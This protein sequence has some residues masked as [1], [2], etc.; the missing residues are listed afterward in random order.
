MSGQ[1]SYPHPVLGVGDDVAGTFE[2]AD[3]AAPID[4]EHDTLS[5]TG[6]FDLEHDSIRK[7]VEAGD[8]RISV[9][10][11]CLVTQYR[12]S[13]ALKDCSSFDLPMP[14]PALSGAVDVTPMVVSSVSMSDYQPQGMHAD[15]GKATFA[16]EPGSVIAVGSSFQFS[17]DP[18]FNGLKDRAESLIVFRPDERLTAQTPFEVDP[19]LP[20]RLVIKVSTEDLAMLRAIGPRVPRTIMSGLVVAAIA[21]AIS[22]VKHP[23]S[24]DESEFESLPWFQRMNELHLR[25]TQGRSLLDADCPLEAA[26]V[27]LDSPLHGGLKELESY[28]FPEGV[29][30]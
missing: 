28:V 22:Q 2:L 5:L 23:Q 26:Q 16:I 18:E 20:E 29:D 24:G 6:R 8:A 27:I 7:A 13:F 19:A 10:V 17:V 4:R 15:Y 11:H 9:R 14:L 21:E 30:E 25:A 12:K 1:Y 3:P